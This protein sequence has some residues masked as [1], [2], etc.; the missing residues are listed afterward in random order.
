MKPNGTLGATTF[1]RDNSFW[2]PDVRS[3][4]ASF[5]FEAPF[6]TEVR[7]QMHDSGEWTDPAWI[8]KHLEEEGFSDV[9]VTVNPGTYKMESAEEFVRTFGM[10]LS[11]LT[12]TWWSEELSEKHPMEEVNELIKEHLEEKYEGKGWDINWLVICMTTRVE[13]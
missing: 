11:W 5:P 6:P 8:E 9:K 4:F 12:K 3:A 13:K 10:M 7:M 2:I 1:H